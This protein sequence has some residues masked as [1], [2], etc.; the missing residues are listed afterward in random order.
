M[1]SS[2]S[3]ITG[4]PWIVRGGFLRGPPS[5][6]CYSSSLPY[7]SILVNL[8]T[9]IQLDAVKDANALLT[10][11]T[12]KIFRKLNFQVPDEEL[13]GIVNRRPYCIERLLIALKTRVWGCWGLVAGW[14]ALSPYSSGCLF[15]L[16]FIFHFYFSIFGV[17]QGIPTVSRKI[18]KNRCLIEDLLRNFDFFGAEGKPWLYHG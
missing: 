1:A 15:L 2:R 5:T 3:F 17:I 14:V 12:E 8:I 4:K 7:L 11:S 6:R 9:F 13:N 10:P 18:G 16:F